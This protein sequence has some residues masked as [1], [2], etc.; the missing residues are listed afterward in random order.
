MDNLTKNFGTNPTNEHNDD[1]LEVLLPC[2]LFSEEDDYDH[3]KGYSQ[4]CDTSDEESLSSEMDDSYETL[5]ENLIL[6]VSCDESPPWSPSDDKYLE[7]WVPCDIFESQLFEEDCFEQNEECSQGLDISD[8]A[9]L[10]SNIDG[11]DDYW[12]II[13]NP[14]YDTFENLIYDMSSKESVYSETYEICKEE[15]SEFSY[16][17]SEL[18]LSIFNED[19]EKQ[20]NEELDWVQLIEYFFIHR[21]HI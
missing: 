6:E 4:G 14:T 9:S 1:S 16:H 11:D 18:Y 12:T 17:E 21:L 3:E 8:E 10:I 2:D 5:I 7:S 20:Y 13:E 19:L 15:Q